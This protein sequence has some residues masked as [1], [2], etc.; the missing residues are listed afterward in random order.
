MFFLFAKINFGL[1]KKYIYIYLIVLK[2]KQEISF[3]YFKDFFVIYFV[4]KC[5]ILQ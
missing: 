2:K 3:F 5:K 4:K 1:K